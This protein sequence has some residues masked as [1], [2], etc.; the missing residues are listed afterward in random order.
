MAPDSEFQTRTVLPIP[1]GM[2]HRAQRTLGHGVFAV[3]G[4]H[5]PPDGVG[6]PVKHRRSENLGQG[7]VFDG[8]APLAD[9]GVSPCGLWR[10]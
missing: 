6:D 2:D 9:L 5:G 1:H 3:V 8:P 4:L 10:S 7:F